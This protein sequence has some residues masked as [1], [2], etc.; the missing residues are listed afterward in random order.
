MG[1][2]EL[3]E[4][5]ANPVSKILALSF[6]LLCSAVLAISTGYATRMFRGAKD[7]N[8]NLDSQTTQTLAKVLEQIVDRLGALDNVKQALEGLTGVISIQS[9][10]ARKNG[11][12]QTQQHIIFTQAI[13][14]LKGDI[15]PSIEKVN[16]AVTNMSNDLKPLITKL[17][18]Q[19]A[20]GLNLSPESMSK[21]VNSVSLEVSKNIKSDLSDNTALIIQSIR[22]AIIETKPIFDPQEKGKETL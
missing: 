6:L 1:T 8:D 5:M 19:L 10:T 7:K 3:N 21:I 11:Q 12:E 9:E 4:L 22:D 15:I 14:N 20:Q 17:T 13:E 16:K 2:S 18:E